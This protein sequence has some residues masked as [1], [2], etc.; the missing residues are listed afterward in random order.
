MT[1]YQVEKPTHESIYIGACEIAET[2]GISRAY[3]Y[4]I[5]KRLND[6]LEAKGKLIISGKT[7]RKY[8]YQ[9]IDVSVA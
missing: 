5:I 8:F 7:N 2:M 3:A 9:K 1:N 4:K 6:E